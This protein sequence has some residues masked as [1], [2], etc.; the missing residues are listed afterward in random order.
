MSKELI[1]DELQDYLPAKQVNTLASHGVPSELKGLNL[2]PLSNDLAE[3]SKL[4]KGKKKGPYKEALDKLIKKH[5]LSAEEIEKQISLYELVLEHKD[6]FLKII[7]AEKRPEKIRASGHYWDNKLKY[8]SPDKYGKQLNIFET[9]EKPRTKEQ[10]AKVD[11]V[12]SDIGINLAPPENK[13]IAALIKLLNDKSDVNNP[14]AENFY[15]GNAKPVAMKNYGGT[16]IDESAPVLKIKPAELY[17]AYLDMKEY[18]GA[19]IKYIKGLVDELARKNFLITYERKKKV[20]KN[21]KEE[22]LT[23]LIEDFQPLFKILRYTPDL[24]E[25]ELA[26]YKKERNN[27]NI[28]EQKG[29]YLLALNPIFIDQIDQKYVEFPRDIEKRTAEAAGGARK[30]TEADIALRDWILRELSNGRSYFEIN[31]EKLPYALKLDNYI[32]AHRKKLIKTRVEQAINVA[33]KLGIL[34]RVITE[35]NRKGEPKLCFHL[36]NPFS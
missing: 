26:H 10:I 15:K 30:V 19:E 35:V 2:T 9:L 29:E 32:R 17:K 18:S 25:E 11:Y 21:G 36:K 12:V 13:L 3:I 1:D 34:D 8:S 24:T 20:V 16:G 7:A 4:R 22:V 14:K 33:K 28:F 6:T 23:D 31:E 5:N 27:N